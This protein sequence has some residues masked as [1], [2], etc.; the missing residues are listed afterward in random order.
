VQCEVRLRL[1]ASG[2][3]RVIFTMSAVRNVIRVGI[4]AG[5]LVSAQTGG[6]KFEVAS[7]RISAWRPGVAAAIG[8]RGAG[9][10]CPQSLKMDRGRVDFK[11]ATLVTLIGYG[12]RFSPER[13]VGPDWLVNAGPTRFDIAATLPEG[14]SEHQV[15]EMVQALL[16]D[17]FKLVVHRSNKEGAIYA[18][19]VAKG[20]PKL[21]MTTEAATSL[22]DAPPGTA[23]YFGG[24]TGRTVAATDGSGAATLISNVRMGTVRETGDQAQI[25]RWEAPSISLAGLADLLD[26]V[27]P[28]SSPIIDKT[29]LGG[30]YRLVLEVSLKDAIGARNDREAVVLRDFNDGLRKLGLQLELRK[31]AIETIVVDHMEKT[32]T[33]N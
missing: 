2:Q 21:A 5:T 18:L 30:R 23:D 24:T 19:V 1:N 3:P 27:A 26:R 22:P 12:F 25:Q 16:A 13:I 8:E 33:E 20:G 29:G 15:P 4:A 11:C 31:G 32:P 9:G 10:G 7:V 6:P 14:A 17:R 28:L